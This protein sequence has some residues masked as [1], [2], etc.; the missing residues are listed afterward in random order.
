MNVESKSSTQ[1][2]QSGKTSYKRA[3]RAKRPTLVTQQEQVMLDESSAQAIEEALQPEI[4]VAEE[5][6][7]VTPKKRMPAFFSNIGRSASSEAD[8]QT[9]RMARAMRGKVVDGPKAK[10]TS[11]AKTNVSSSKAGSAPARPKPRSGFKMRYIWGMMA[12]L[13]IADFLGVWI[14]SLMQSHGLDAP[15]FQWGAFKADR[16]TLVFL[17]LLILILIVM[18][19]LDFIPSS[20]KAAMN[21]SSPAPAPRKG[22]VPAKK[23]TTSATF[24]T[25]REQPTMRQGESG[26]DDNL[27]REYRE[28]QRYFQKRDRKRS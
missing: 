2:T 1:G 18:A 4:P 3:H 21:G 28:N 16:S 20:F 10:E 26:Q 24:D 5:T 27:Y 23:K 13:L 12:Y 8:P 15:V 19:R 11:N 14:Q 17:V 7:V 9:A 6:P 25:R 22:S